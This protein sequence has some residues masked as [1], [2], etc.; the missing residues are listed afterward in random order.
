MSSPKDKYALP[1]RQEVFD[2]S[3]DLCIAKASTELLD[4]LL[5]LP[6]VFASSSWQLWRPSAGRDLKIVTLALFA[7]AMGTRIPA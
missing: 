5:D 7:C 6:E 2:K 1:H 4:E 3:V